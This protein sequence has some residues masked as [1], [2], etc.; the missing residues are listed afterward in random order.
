MYNY[1]LMEELTSRRISHHRA[2]VFVVAMLQVL[3]GTAPAHAE[4]PSPD[5]HYNSTFGY[6]LAQQLNGRD[7]G[8]RLVRTPAS[9]D[10]EIVLFDAAK[11][12]DRPSVDLEAASVRVGEAGKYSSVARVGWARSPATRFA[13][14][15]IAD[16]EFLQHFAVAS[17]ASVFHPKLGTMLV[18]FQSPAVAAEE[19]R[20]CEDNKMTTWGIDPRAWHALRSPPQPLGDFRSWIRPESANLTGRTSGQAVVRLTIS[21]DGT[22]KDC[23]AIDPSIAAELNA[24]ACRGLSRSGRF[25]PAY[26]DESEPVESPYVVVVEFSLRPS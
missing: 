23:Q 12:G 3:I 7:Y 11:W 15:L 22:V 6:C 9:D 25:I 13:S 17:L 4:S 1:E 19:L 2:F 5:W 16:P 26:D 21:R 24:A 18:A 20:K 10:T 8:I 14:V